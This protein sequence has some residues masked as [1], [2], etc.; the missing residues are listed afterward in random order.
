[1]HVLQKRDI[2]P[3]RVR[4]TKNWAQ[5]TILKFTSNLKRIYAHFDT[6]RHISH[7]AFYTCAASFFSPRFNRPADFSPRAAQIASKLSIYVFDSPPPCEWRMIPR[8]C[9][10]YSSRPGTYARFLKKE[11]ERKRGTKSASANKCKYLAGEGYMR[12]LTDVAAREGDRE[13]VC[14]RVAAL[15]LVYATCV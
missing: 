2:D 13:C 14:T 15:I 5:Q 6:P 7:S 11:V 12:L 9:I 4:K 10:H 1:M 3:N 8:A